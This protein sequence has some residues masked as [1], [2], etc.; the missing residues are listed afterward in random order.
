LNN[1]TSVEAKSL[2]TSIQSLEKARSEYS[3]AKSRLRE[4]VYD[5]NLNH[6]IIDDFEKNEPSSAVIEQSAYKLLNGMK[7]SLGNLIVNPLSD[8][9]ENHEAPF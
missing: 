4:V 7:E 8:E 6:Y 1:S 9:E 2:M 3:I 5:S